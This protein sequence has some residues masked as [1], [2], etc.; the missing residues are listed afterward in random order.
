[1]L[2]NVSATQTLACQCLKFTI[3]FSSVQLEWVVELSI[4][5]RYGDMGWL[6]PDGCGR[7]L[8]VYPAKRVMLLTMVWR[9]T[10]DDDFLEDCSQL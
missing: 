1:V 4:N 7:T 3:H 6:V 5:F 10:R 8:Q 9:P 2:T